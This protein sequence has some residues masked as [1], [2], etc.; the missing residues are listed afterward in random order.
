MDN[1]HDAE[2]V[3]GLL[4]VDGVA[5]GDDAAGL[6]DLGSAAAQYLGEYVGREVLRES[7]NVQGEHNLAAHGEDVAHGVGGGDSAIGVG[8]IHHRREEVDGLDY[9]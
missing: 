4:V 9:R 3:L 8:I 2:A 1:T 7:D 6:R 5:T